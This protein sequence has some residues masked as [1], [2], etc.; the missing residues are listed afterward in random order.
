MPTFK[1]NSVPAGILALDVVAVVLDEVPIFMNASFVPI[2]QIITEGPQV[3][4]CVLEVVPVTDKE[5]VEQT[6]IPE[7]FWVWAFA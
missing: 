3:D 5:D 2:F 7:G 1:T 4:S 6:V